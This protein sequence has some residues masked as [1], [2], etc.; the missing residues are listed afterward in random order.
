[1]SFDGRSSTASSRSSSWNR[2]SNRVLH[3]VGRGCKLLD[4]ARARRRDEEAIASVNDVGD[5][6]LFP[7]GHLLLRSVVVAI[8]S[9]GP[10]AAL[11]IEHEPALILVRAPSPAI[12]HAP[13]GRRIAVHELGER[14]AVL[15]ANDGLA[16]GNALV[17]L[18]EAHR[19]DN[20]DNP[21]AG[22][23]PRPT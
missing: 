23:L 5:D 17:S 15:I 6:A 13:E 10:H 21:A 4:R 8:L 1:M 19:R 12:V 18:G 16:N 3:G 20:L 11:D 14:L 2:R 9:L 7:S 22:A